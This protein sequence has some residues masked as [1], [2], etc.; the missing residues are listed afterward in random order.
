MLMATINQTILIISLPAVFRGIHIDPLHSGQTSLL[1]WI[2]MGFN[3]ATTILLVSLER[4]PIP[5]GGF[6]YTIWG[7]WF[8]PWAPF[9]YF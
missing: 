4:F 1:L 5:I 3:V 6:A 9:Y 2:F 8:S 7:F